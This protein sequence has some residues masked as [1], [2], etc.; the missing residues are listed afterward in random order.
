MG[1]HDTEKYATIKAL[2]DIPEDEPIFILR[3]QDYTAVDAIDHYTKVN[4]R[5]GNDASW[6]DQMR[7]VKDSF[8]DWAIK[9]SDKVKFPD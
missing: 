6:L 9:N 4:E 3:A 5:P 1:V 8:V 7:R 2:L